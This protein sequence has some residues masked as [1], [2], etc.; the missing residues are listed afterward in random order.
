MASQMTTSHRRFRQASRGS[1]P[2]NEFASGPPT[3]RAAVRPGFGHSFTRLTLAARAIESASVAPIQQKEAD[4][5]EA[6][7]DSALTLETG[8]QSAGIQ[9]GA[10][11]RVGTEP[12]APVLQ[13]KL[14]MASGYTEMLN[15]S[16]EAQELIETYE[17]F[18]KLTDTLKELMVGSGFRNMR[19]NRLKPL[20]EFR[21]ALEQ[22]QIP[23]DA[24]IRRQKT[25]EIEMKLP[26]AQTLLNDVHRK[27]GTTAPR[28]DQ[29]IEGE[30]E[31]DITLH[32][33]GE[34]E[35][36]SSGEGSDARLSH[37][38]PRG[39]A[40]EEADEPAETGRL[41]KARDLL[42]V[43]NIR[44]VDGDAELTKKGRAGEAS[45]KASGALKANA[46]DGL[47]GE[48]RVEISVVLG[49]KAEKTIDVVNVKGVSVR[50]KVEGTVGAATEGSV[51]RAA[52]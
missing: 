28:E 30:A 10:P 7:A 45:A 6:D 46:E 49:K 48:G 16:G 33:H 31:N 36:A 50:T 41:A 32:S 21:T 26:I 39:P 12:G 23:N 38:I 19:R 13:A 1:G 29:E 43:V 17:K 5:G 14:N 52:A 37:L 20:L 47:Q 34:H 24:T 22:T 44:L 9:V 40:E 35:V 42:S 15:W 8:F 3:P 25:A 51:R 18:E 2:S 4:Q 11:R 27:R